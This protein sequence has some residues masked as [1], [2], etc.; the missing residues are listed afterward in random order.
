VNTTEI[1]KYKELSFEQKVQILKQMNKDDFSIDFSGGDVLIDP[2]NLKLIELASRKFGKENIGLSIPGTFLTEE[3]VDFLKNK[4]NDI[5]LTLDNLPNIQDKT[6][7]LNYAK[8]SAIALQRLLKHNLNVGV[9]TV[10]NHS[11]MNKKTI[12]NLFKFLEKIGVKKWSFIKFFPVGNFYRKN[13]YC[14]SDLEY[15]EIGEYIKKITQKSDIN[16]HFQYLYPRKEKNEFACRAVS[17]S[18]GINAI[19]KVSSCFWA[20]NKQGDPLE[21]F[22]LG[23]VPKENI[24]DILSSN[25]AYNWSQQYNKCNNCELLKILYSNV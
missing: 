18:I 21:E 12:Y 25:K 7:P 11:N 15:I 4:V 8:I 6:R 20:L 22:Y 9:Q 16:V 3:Y 23:E 19:G 5:E 24:Y 10:L 17:K 1:N 13:N 14:P 2:N